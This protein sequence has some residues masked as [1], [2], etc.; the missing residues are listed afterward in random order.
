LE[1]EIRDP[2]GLPSV[3]LLMGDRAGD[4]SQIL[5][6]AEALGW[7]VEIKRFV[8][9]PWEGLLNL[10]FL[11][12]LAGVDKSQSSHLEPPWPDLV[13]SAGRRNE[14]IARW[15][16][17]QARGRVKLVH[18]GRPW[19]RIECFDLVVTTPQYR[20]PN[21]PMVLQNET[22]LHRVNR[23]RLDEAAAAWEPRLKHLKRPRIA[24]LAGGNSGP[25]TFDPTAGARL[26]RQASELA[27]SSGGSLLVTTSART[28]PDT[29]RALF[30]ALRC[31]VY[32]FRW[33]PEAAENPYFGFLGLADAIIATADSVSMMAEACST[34]RPVYLFDTGSGRNAMHRANGAEAAPGRAGAWPLGRQPFKA[35]I[36]RLTMRAGPKRLTRDIRLVQ[37]L[38]VSS[39]RAAWLGDGD[40]PEDPPPLRD[41]ERAVERVRKLFQAPANT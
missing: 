25:Y 1:I 4:N 3:W 10:P 38:L 5:G 13:I 2:E 41:L 19:A 29:A 15:I 21:L 9:T 35:W 18:V 32:C 28:A 14:P 17:Q 11:R 33:T 40:A 37:A 20:L 34:G 16:Q 36:Y 30:D 6:L 22:P 27:L 24:V 12:T 7:P 26:G 31:P 8:Y 39:G 23:E